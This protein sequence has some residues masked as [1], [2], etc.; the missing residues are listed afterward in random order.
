MTKKQIERKKI[1]F[2]DESW[3][4]GDNGGICD[5]CK[6]RAKKTIQVELLYYFCEKCFLGDCND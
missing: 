1:I 5:I 6:R 2:D 4:Y 3:N